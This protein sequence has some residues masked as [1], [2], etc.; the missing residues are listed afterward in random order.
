MSKNKTVMVRIRVEDKEIL[1][2][3]SEKKGMKIPVI[4]SYLMEQ[5]IKYSMFDEGWLEEL[6]K[7]SLHQILLETD[8]DYK[9]GFEVAK[10][11]AIL[12]TQQMLIKEFITSMPSSERNSYIKNVL[13]DPN[14]DNLLEVLTTQQIYSVN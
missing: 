8:L 14:K 10:Y 9:K 6:T 13:G 1:D 12:K 5:A 2:D 11:K 3:I 7:V 4:L